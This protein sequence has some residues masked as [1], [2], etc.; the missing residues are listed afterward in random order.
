MPCVRLKSHT[1]TFTFT[2]TF[3]FSSVKVNELTRQVEMLL[4]EVDNSKVAYREQE[5]EMRGAIK[6]RDAA[7]ASAKQQRDAIESARDKIETTLH[8][9]DRLVSFALFL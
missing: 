6:E 5:E 7:L 4:T 3:P 2:F 8:K 9:K 1:F